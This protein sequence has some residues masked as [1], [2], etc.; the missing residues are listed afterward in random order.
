MAISCGLNIQRS[1]SSF[2]VTSLEGASALGD[3][4]G[5]AFADLGNG[6]ELVGLLRGE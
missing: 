6:P 3:S 2:F 1:G 4:G 5:L